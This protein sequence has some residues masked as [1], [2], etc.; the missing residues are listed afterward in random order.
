MNTVAAKGEKAKELQVT[1]SQYEMHLESE[2]LK[3][4]TGQ[5][6]MTAKD[7][8]A[9]MRRPE[10]PTLIGRVKQFQNLFVRMSRSPPRAQLTIGIADGPTIC[11]GK[12]Q[13]GQ[14]TCT[15]LTEE[16]TSAGDTRTGP[17]T[18][19]Q[20]FEPAAYVQAAKDVESVLGQLSSTTIEYKLRVAYSEN[21]ADL[22]IE[23]GRIFFLRKYEGKI[24]KT[25]EIQFTQLEPIIKFR[26]TIGKKEA[27]S[28][29]STFSAGLDAKAM[30][31]PQNY[32][33]V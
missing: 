25:W 10:T 19:A 14:L 24:I 4:A 2:V 17:I 23:N 7:V 13:A 5:K 27:L 12:K 30:E 1:R 33:V 8:M 3:A 26:P 9:Q 22:V 6:P 18:A 32:V 11:A 28:A 21:E 20:G 15:A 31:R 29:P 16:A